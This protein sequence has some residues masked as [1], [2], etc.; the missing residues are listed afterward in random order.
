MTFSSWLTPADTFHQ[1]FSWFCMFWGAANIII[2][3]VVTQLLI[4]VMLINCI[5]IC[6]KV[7]NWDNAHWA[8][9][10]VYN[11]KSLTGRVSTVRHVGIRSNMTMTFIEKIQR[12]RKKLYF[13]MGAHTHTLTTGL[14]ECP[15]IL[16]LWLSWCWDAK[17]L[18]W[19]A[20]DRL[21]IMKQ[22]SLYV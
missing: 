14:W 17:S 10:T 20:P 11:L 18:W 13:I 5:H 12:C 4:S 1:V 7:G 9:W 19:T 8:I 6:L 21:N 2:C 22:R 3:T 16:H 15:D